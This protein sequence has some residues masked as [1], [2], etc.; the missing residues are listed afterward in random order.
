[1]F[2]KQ[3]KFW[4]SVYR[5]THKNPTPTPTLTTPILPTLTTPTLQRP[6]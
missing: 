4:Q 3:P 5:T 6:G 1:M 2:L